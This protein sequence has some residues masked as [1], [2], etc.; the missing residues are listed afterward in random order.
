VVCYWAPLRQSLL[1]G[2]RHLAIERER[3]VRDVGPLIDSREAQP[4]APSHFGQSHGIIQTPANG[5]RK[6]RGGTRRYDQAAPLVLHEFRE[7]ADTGCDDWDAM[8]LGEDND[9]ARSDVD[10]WRDQ[11]VSGAQVAGY[12]GLRHKGRMHGDVVAKPELIYLPLERAKGHERLARNQQVSTREL[13]NDA[14]HGRQQV[15][16]ALVRLDLSKE[17][18]QLT[19][20]ADL[21]EPPALTAL[22]SSREGEGIATMRLPHSPA[23]ALGRRC[24]APAGLYERSPCRWR[25]AGV[26]TLRSAFDERWAAVG[27]APCR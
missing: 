6:S 26:G 17:E 25:R 4:A 21:Q 7:S 15:R 16:Q 3:L 9:T 20:V 23:L 27:R 22:L 10:V 11:Q 5:I 14:W 24:H 8:S 18:K 19:I 13:A 12:V 1:I 2:D